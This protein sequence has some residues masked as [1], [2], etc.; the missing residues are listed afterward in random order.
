M[1]QFVN[2]DDVA[3]LWPDGLSTDPDRTQKLVD[4]AV[5]RIINRVPSIP[6]RLASGSLDKL[7][8][9]G[10]VAEVVARAIRADSQDDAEQVTDAAGPFSR[11]RRYG[12]RVRITDADLIDLLPPATSGN[13]GKWG[14]VGLGLRPY[15]IPDGA[16]SSAAEFA[17][18]LYAS[19]SVA[20]DPIPD[21]IVDTDYAA[22]LGE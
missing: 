8:L 6:S 12:D 9:V 17:G 18:P 20:N 1:N 3:P 14:S 7:L 2:V 22:M 16:A 10:A 21:E 4:L 13:R 19:R 15:Q 5:A 11:T